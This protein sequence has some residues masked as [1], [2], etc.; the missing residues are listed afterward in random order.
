MLMH[1]SWPVCHHLTATFRT[2]RDPISGA[3]GLI[4]SIAQIGAVTGSTFATG[5]GKIGI[6]QLFLF[7]R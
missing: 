2:P 7:A 3:Y 6:A 4:L 5:S 1:C